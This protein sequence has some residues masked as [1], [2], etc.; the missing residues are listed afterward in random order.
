MATSRATPPPRSRAAIPGSRRGS[1][2]AGARSPWPQ[3]RK[4]RLHQC[5]F[6]LAVPAPSLRRDPQFRAVETEDFTMTKTDTTPSAA[7]RELAVE[8]LQQAAGGAFDHFLKLEGI[9]G[10]SRNR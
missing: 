8:E 1:P 7:P 5:A 4:P 10:E 2:C 6:T 3:I 9:K